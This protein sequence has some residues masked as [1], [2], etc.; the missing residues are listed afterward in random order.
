MTNTPSTINVWHDLYILLRYQW[1]LVLHI[2]PFSCEMQYL[3]SFCRFHTPS[4]CVNSSW[5]VRH[6]GRM[7][8][9][10]PHMLKRRLGLSLLYTETKLSSQRMDVTDRGRR[11]LMSQN[12]ARPLERQKMTLIQQHNLNFSHVWL[13]SWESS[14]NYNHYETLQN[15]QGVPG[16]TCKP[17]NYIKV[18]NTS[19]SIKC[20]FRHPFNP[21]YCV[22]QP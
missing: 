17:N 8:H 6:F 14:I 13:V 15:L 21:P 5:V 2:Q 20:L 22:F 3:T 11:F 19:Y 7:R 9:S 12:T 4:L 1:P 10:K 16:S 18:L